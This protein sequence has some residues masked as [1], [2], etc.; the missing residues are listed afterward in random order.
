MLK[1]LLLSLLSPNP[2]PDLCDQMYVKPVGA[3]GRGAGG[4][5]HPVDRLPAP[6]TRSPKGPV[7][8]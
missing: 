3:R 1:L 7:D 4:G 2:H 5:V 8:L 6:L